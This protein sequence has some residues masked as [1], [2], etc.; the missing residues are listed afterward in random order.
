MGGRS[1][2]R[3]LDVG[4]PDTV[5]FTGDAL[6]DLLASSVESTVV[7]ESM[8]KHERERTARTFFP[9]PSSS[10]PISRDP[11]SISLAPL[12]FTPP[13]GV[14]S[15][16]PPPKLQPRTAAR[17]AISL[18]IGVGIG[19]LAA[20]GAGAAQHGASAAGAQ[21]RFA[22]AA[23][24]ERLAIDGPMRD[25]AMKQRKRVTMM[26]PMR[27]AAPATPAAPAPPALDALGD[28]QLGRPF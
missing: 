10:S 13:S 8:P 16:A 19:L 18:A 15:A 23:S 7:L 22:R 5:A 2:A 21:I 12:T 25:K 11:G 28:A 14:T 6:A 27:P 1:E 20:V 26:L 9:P 24:D 4:E 3:F 17:A